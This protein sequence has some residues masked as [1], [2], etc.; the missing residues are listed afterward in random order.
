MKTLRYVI[1]LAALSL[2]GCETQTSE[3]A[4]II[5]KLS[6]CEK[7]LAL[8]DQ[9]PKQ[10][11][12]LRL[13]PKNTGAITVWDARH[14]L[15]GKDCQVWGWGN[16]KTNYMCSKTAPNKAVAMEYFTAAKTF[17]ESCIGNSWALEERPRK[18]G[19]GIK[20]T[21]SRPNS[22]TVVAMHA[23][24]TNGLFNNEWTAYFFVGD[25]NDSL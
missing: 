21:F 14:H 4:Q 7:V 13:N 20:A 1:P 22:E 19:T 24:E 23:V 12:S 9:H 5:S 6:N 15:I 25:G 16:N 2:L 17:T 18:V 3:E 10:F 11:S 8:V